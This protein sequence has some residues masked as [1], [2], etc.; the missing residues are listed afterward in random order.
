MEKKNNLP[1]GWEEIEFKKI[2]NNI[3]LTGKKIQQRNYEERG[4]LPVIDQGQNFI[5]GYTNKSELKVDC[6]L[7]VIVFGDHTKS[8]KFVTEEFVAGADGVK[9]LESKNVLIP[10]LLY[11]FIKAISLPNKGYAR[12]Y[13]FLATSSIRIPPLNEQKR[14]IAKIDELFSQVE[15]I[16]ELIQTIK[17]QLESYHKIFL[18]NALQGKILPSPSGSNPILEYVE[19][20]RK[21]IIEQEIKRKTI[22]NH[23]FSSKIASVIAD[24]H[25]YI[26]PEHWRW[27]TLNSLIHPIRGITYG[28]IKLGSEVKDGVPCLRTSD[29]KPLKIENNN[30]KKISKKIADN[31]KRTYLQG[32]EVLINVRGTLGGI[33][34]VSKSLKGYNISREIAIAPVLSILPPKW[35]MYWVSSI[36]IQNWLMKSTRGI[37]YRGINLEDLRNLPICL[38]PLEEMNLLIDEIEKHLSRISYLKQKFDNYLYTDKLKSKILELAFEGKLIPQDPTDEPASELLKRIKLQN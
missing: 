14:I 23:T 15:V 27:T 35:I 7:P 34:V 11:Y 8:V 21:K 29:V 36:G 38:P 19:C 31:Y 32:G 28:V 20:E 37:A 1:T 13:Q 2:I 25:I 30:V 10:K 26:S 9:V 6:A 12:H 33:C 22:K 24:D 16:V 4:Q 3:S 18:V 5:G 17:K